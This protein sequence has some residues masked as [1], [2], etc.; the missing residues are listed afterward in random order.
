M[1]YATA[2]AAKPAIAACAL[3]D[4]LKL[5]IGQSCIMPASSVRSTD[6]TLAFNALESVTKMSSPPAKAKMGGKP[7]QFPKIGLHRGSVRGKSPAYKLPPSAIPLMVKIPSRGSVFNWSGCAGSR[8][9]HGQM[10]NRQPAVFDR[11]RVPFAP[12]PR[13]SRPLRSRHP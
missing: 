13:S 2:R 4:S 10:S 3:R 12:M 9:S 5:K 1:R 8:S 11:R 7:S 6:G